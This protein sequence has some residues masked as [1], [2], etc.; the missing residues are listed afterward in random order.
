MKRLLAAAMLAGCGAEPA[1][2]PRDGGPTWTVQRGAYP[3]V[4]VAP[5]D[6]AVLSW[7]GGDD[8]R[9]GIRVRTGETWS[10]WFTMAVAAGGKLSSV[11]QKLVDVDTLLLPAP[12]RAFQVRVEGGTVRSIAVT[13]WLRSAPRTSSMA[14][15]AAWGR[16][17][18]VPLR[19]QTSERADLAGRICSPTSL[20][21]ALEFFG[22]N[23][24]TEEL[25]GLV[26]DHDAKIYGNWSFNAAVAGRLVGESFVVRAEGFELL[27]AEIA[28]GRPVVLSHKWKKGELTGAP[29]ESSDGH[30]IVVAGFTESG[31]VVVNDPAAKPGAVRRVYRRAELWRTWQENASGIVYLFRPRQ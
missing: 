8:C 12:A 9:V 28:A 30:L 29:V 11:K 17:L 15:A 16:T 31:D 22:V 19:S 1:P 27:E 24:A 25:A 7:N 23:R 14:R 4:E 2:P 5:F 10:A 21:M 6:A 18:E 20:A 26:Y 3:E 13:H